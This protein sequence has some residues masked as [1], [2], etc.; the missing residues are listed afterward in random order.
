MKTSPLFAF[1]LAATVSG[2]AFA[3]ITIDGSLADWQIDKST[4]VSS[5]PG[6]H[7][8]IED[9]T[10][11]SGP[12][13]LNPGYG[14]QDY[15]AEAMYAVIQDGKLFIA[16]ATGHNPNT[17]DNPGSNI[18]AAGDFAIDFGKDGSYE[19]G[20]NVVNNFSGGALGGIY[21]SPLWAY[22]LWD[23]N[24]QETHDP[25]RAD[26]SHP[27]SLLG[28]ALI[29]MA[30]SQYTTVGET[31]YGSQAGDAHYFYEISLDLQVLYAAGWDGGEF[32]IHWTQNCAND[33]IMVAMNG[34]QSVPEPG[35]LAL[36]GIGMIG[37]IG[38][39][40]GLRRSRAATP[41]TGTA[42]G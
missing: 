11:G 19:L 23:A 31:G 34:G 27:T 12:Y 4:W 38:G 29:G 6:V 28:G 2:S 3:G 37:L 10:G 42:N 8:T 18:F 26:K 36:L 16:L 24:G 41:G 9:Q 20:I 14:G 7:S 13:F 30:E 25:D 15:D 22:G 5:L 32:G 35:S 33:N 40:R 21:A 1:A 39:K 17:P